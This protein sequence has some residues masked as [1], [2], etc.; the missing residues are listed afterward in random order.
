MLDLLAHFS[1]Q[2]VTRG[3][4][5]DSNKTRSGVLLSLQLYLLLFQ[6]QK[7]N[8]TP[9]LNFH[10]GLEAEPSLFLFES[11]RASGRG[12]TGTHR[13][14]ASCKRQRLWT[15]LITDISIPLKWYLKV[16][17]NQL[18]GAEWFCIAK[19]MTKNKAKASQDQIAFFWL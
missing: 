15:E 11:A 9:W 7:S 12:G 16:N 5:G 18:Q 19:T 6:R 3:V 13:I 2:N 10:N 14:S 8:S 4:S 1:S 17:P